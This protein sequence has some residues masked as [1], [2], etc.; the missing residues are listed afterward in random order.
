MGNA[1]LSLQFTVPQCSGDWDIS[2][3]VDQ[4]PIGGQ[5]FVLW[6][7]DE[8]RLSG[9]GANCVELD[10]CDLSEFIDDG[11]FEAKFASFTGISE[12]LLSECATSSTG[13]PTSDPNE[14]SDPN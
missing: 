7:Y 11:S 5:R 14:T 6:S 1:V 13:S 10:L 4:T 8:V 9:S 3:I 2:L 12:E